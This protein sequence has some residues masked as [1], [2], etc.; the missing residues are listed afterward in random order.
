MKNIVIGVASA[1]VLVLL[2]FCIYTLQG[3]A[4]RKT[5]SS[6]SITQ[7][8]ENAGQPLCRT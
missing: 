1:I 6:D 2:L 4:T 3:E 8:M 5:E 7:A